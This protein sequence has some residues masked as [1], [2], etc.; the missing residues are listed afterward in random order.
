M[1]F[2]IKKIFKRD[3]TPKYELTRHNSSRSFMNF[4]YIEQILQQS[5]LRTT[6][7]NH[8]QIYFLRCRSINQNNALSLNRAL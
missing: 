4:P 7:I 8:T 2:L 3:I 6:Q 5:I 1:R